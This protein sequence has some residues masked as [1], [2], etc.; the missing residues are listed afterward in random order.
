MTTQLEVFG[1]FGIPFDLV[2]SVKKIGKA[3]ETAFWAQDGVDQFK[4]K[5]G[6]YIFA[7][8]AAKGFTPWYVGRAGKGFVKE[9]FTPDKVVKYREV[10]DRGTRGSPVMFFVTKGGSRNKVGTKVIGEVEQALIVAAGAKN[11]NLVNVHHNKDREWCIK[12]VMYS[13]PGKPTTI[14]RQFKAMMGMK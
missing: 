2:G 10:F 1:P 6:V 9:I 14:A 11:S 12:G 8:R 3:E 13:S 5:H 4:T 7:M